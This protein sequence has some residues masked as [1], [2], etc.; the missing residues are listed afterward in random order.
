MP[1]GTDGFVIY[2]L[3]TVQ[4]QDEIIMADIGARGLADLL[5]SSVAKF[6]QSTS[7]T[8]RRA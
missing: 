4:R 5:R 7:L 1:T 2:W 6:V 8:L 3:S